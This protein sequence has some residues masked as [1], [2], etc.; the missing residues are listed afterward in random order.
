[1]SQ[2]DLREYELI[3]RAWRRLAVPDRDMIKMVYVWRAHREIICRRL[4]IRRSPASIYDLE[5]AAARRAMI[6][7][8]RRQLADVVLD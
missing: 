6:A 7:E 4:H 3:T 5:L 8:I 1:M 2:Q